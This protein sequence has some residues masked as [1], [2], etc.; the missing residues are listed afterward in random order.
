MSHM[1]AS[2]AELLRQVEP[3][4]LGSRVRAMRQARGWTQAELAG[5]AMTVGYVSR[6]ESGSR[7]PTLTVVGTIA[8]RLGVQVEQLLL[9]VT[10]GE[11]DEIRL[12]LD[13]AELALENGEAFEA[14]ERAR[15]GLADAEKASL[16][17][18]AERGRFL[19]ARALESSGDLDTAITE[20]ETLVTTAR[21]LTAIQAGIALS[22]CYRE[23]GDL[24]LAIEVGE[25]LAPVID[26]AALSET[27]EAVQLTVT[28]AAAYIERGDLHRAARICARAVETAEALATPRARSAAYWN[29]SYIQAQRGDVAAA[30]P[31]ASRAL[32]L[33]AEGNDGRNLARLRLQLGRLQLQMDPPEVDEA[34]A[35]VR[36]ARQELLTTSASDVDRAYGDIVLAQAFVLTGLPERALEALAPAQAVAGDHAAA[37]RA[38][39]L[40]VRGQALVGLSRREEAHQAF[41]E[42]VLALTGA[43][44]DR[45][46]AQ[47]WF[48]IA[49]L[50]D[51]IGDHDAA[52]EAYRS[53]AAASGLSPR[54]R[55]R[56]RVATP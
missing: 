50:M 7:R 36:Q 4:E 47:L 13:Y 33:L 42:A 40:M 1:D 52:R 18:L 3:R 5:D 10:A 31:L 9:G 37:V 15:A 23:T 11:H 46:A 44:A 56:V 20:L 55:L 24:A 12:V 39:A 48:E 25:R 17:R 54:P 51:E 6:I 29:A 22:R 2:H 30:L 43:G 16:T 49:D 28:V 34:I 27:D 21:G 35:H 53:A 41:R 14:E 32:S 26:D 45:S 8:R 38:E 19:L